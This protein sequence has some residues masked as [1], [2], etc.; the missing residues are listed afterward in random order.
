[1]RGISELE[2]LERWMQAVAMHPRGAAHGLRAPGARALLPMAARDLESVVTRSQQLTALDRLGIYA[3]MYYLRLIEVLT[4]EYPT[5]RTILGAQ[6]FEEAC[7]AFIARHPST[8]RTLQS[9]S[10]GFPLFLKRH[11]RGRR[12]ARLAVDVARIERAMED[13]FDA[14]RAAPLG[15]EALERIPADRWGDVR[16]TLTPALRLLAL[17]CP[18]D[19]YMTA[20]R[21]RRKARAPGARPSFVIVYRHNLRAWRTTVTREQFRLLELIGKGWP[22][23]RAVIRSCRH[24]RV[25]ADRLPAL[26]S[27]WFRDWSAAGLWVGIAEPTQS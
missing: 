20:V 14:P 26:L 2:R 23:G 1:M 22:V 27:R 12:R 9:L 8:K 24:L 10:A 6:A 19:A 5:T 13:V 16:L 18:A 21:T 25:R 3:D 4:A 17:E 7:R 15:S 11:L